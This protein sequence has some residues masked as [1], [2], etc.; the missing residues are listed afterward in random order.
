MVL[1]WFSGV[2]DGAG[3]LCGFRVILVLGGSR[4]FW[5]GY[6][7]LNSTCGSSGFHP[8]P[9]QTWNP[10]C[11]T[12]PLL[13]QNLVVTASG[14]PVAVDVQDEVRGA[15]GQG[16][17]VPLLVGQAVGEDLS[18]GLLA[19]P[20]QVVEPQLA[21]L[22]AALQ[23]QQ[24]AAPSTAGS[25][26]ALLACT[27]PT[28]EPRPFTHPD[29][30]SAAPLVSLITDTCP[31]PVHPI[32]PHLSISSSLRSTSVHPFIFSPIICSSFPS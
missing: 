5:C 2:L 1:E 10:T 12:S 18:V 17:A 8:S 9:S 13:G 11:P 16:E 32:I 30:A 25:E 23:L 20:T 26:G 7:T 21:A 6:R 14:S 19:T 22:A 29:D 15:E 3:W 24:P 4:W 31:S 28:V 27:W